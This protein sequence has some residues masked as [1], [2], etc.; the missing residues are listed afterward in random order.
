MLVNGQLI[1][2]EAALD[3]FHCLMPT[4]GCVDQRQVEIQNQKHEQYAFDKAI[5]HGKRIRSCGPYIQ[6]R[7]YAIHAMESD[8]YKIRYG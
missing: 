8:R 4:G 1:A 2:R 6:V 3:H 5:L 7:A